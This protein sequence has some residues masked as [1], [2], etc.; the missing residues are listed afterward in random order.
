ML[1]VGVHDEWYSFVLEDEPTAKDV[2]E[3]EQRVHYVMVY[4]W[5]ACRKLSSAR[6]VPIP[7]PAERRGMTVAGTVVHGELGVSRKLETCFPRII[8]EMADKRDMGQLPSWRSLFLSVEGARQTYELLPDPIAQKTSDLSNRHVN[9]QLTMKVARMLMVNN[10]EAEVRGSV[11]D[12]TMKETCNERRY[13]KR[14]IL[15]LSMI[16]TESL[17]KRQ[18]GQYDTPRLSNSGRR[19][20]TCRS[21]SD[22]KLFPDNGLYLPLQRVIC[23]CTSVMK[24]CSSCLSITVLAPDWSQG[25]NN[26]TTIT[27]ECCCCDSYKSNPGIHIFV[28]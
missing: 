16:R 14:N 4:S 5:K 18:V 26:R 8:F 12:S 10:A 13:V 2:D 6:A 25:F 21:R 7:R 17:S 11:G 9:I 27:K 19:F 1:R 22:I 24:G 23:T 20:E 28:A 15:V 3:R